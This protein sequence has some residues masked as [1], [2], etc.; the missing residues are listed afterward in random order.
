ML[1]IIICYCIYVGTT[2]YDVLNIGNCITNKHFQ[3]LH[4]TAVS[5]MC[6]TAVKTVFILQMFVIKLI[7]SLIARDMQLT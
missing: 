1:F 7:F 6:P 4:L 2:K 3:F 5:N